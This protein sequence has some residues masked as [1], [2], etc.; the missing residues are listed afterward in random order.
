MFVAILIVAVVISAFF[1][2]QQRRHNL[3]LQ[4]EFE[5]LG[6]IMPKERPKLP[7]LES[8]ANVLVGLILFEIGALSLW[9]FLSVLGNAGQIVMRLH[10]A[11]EIDSIASLLAA[12]IALM[13]LGLKSVSANLAFRKSSALN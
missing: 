7:M 3:E 2:Q 12:G 11:G 13:I 8:I 5:K 10:P 4:V 9:A 6:R 1:D